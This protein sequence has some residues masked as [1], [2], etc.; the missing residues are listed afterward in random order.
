MTSLFSPFDR[1]N[2]S[3]KF[4]VIFSLIGGS[5]VLVALVVA[6][7]VIHIFDINAVN[8]T[9]LLKAQTIDN[10]R[11]EASLVWQYL[12][13][14]AL[15]KDQ[16]SITDKADPAKRRAD[17][18]LTEMMAI[19]GL[20]AAEQK[21]FTEA[22]SRLN[23][24]Y[25]AGLAMARAYASDKRSGDLAMATF[26][27]E[28][29]SLL[30]S[31]EQTV[32]FFNSGVTAAVA[33]RDQML[34]QV[35]ALTI[36]T[37]I[38]LIVMT[39]WFSSWLTRYITAPMKK[40]SAVATR[41]AEG[42]FTFRIT[43]IRQKD[44]LGTVSHEV[45]D[46]ADQLE[47][48]MKEIITSIEFAG[49]GKYYRKP[50]SSGLRGMLGKAAQ[51]VEHSLHEQELRLKRS[52]EDKAYLAAKTH[53]LLTAMDRFA[54]GDLTMSVHAEKDDE[55]GQLFAGFNRSVQ[56]LHAR[57][58]EVNNAAEEATEAGS[59][60]SSG[61]T[62]MAAGAEEQSA[63][64]GEVASAMEEMSRS[65]GENAQQA[66]HAVQIAVRAR[67]S[68]QNGGAVV[69]KTVDG[70]EKITHVFR[71]SADTM[72]TLG[73]SSSQIGEIVGVINDIA[74]Q[75]NLLALNAA[76]EAA[77]AGTHGRGFAVVAD[78]VRK[79]AERTTKATKEISV[80]IHRIQEETNQAVEGIEKGEKDVEEERQLVAHAGESLKEIVAT[81]NTVTDMI[82][83]IAAANSEQAKASE[84][85][86]RNIV[87]IAAVTNENTKAID[88]I[89]RSADQV[90]Q[91][92]ANLQGLVSS[93]TLTSEDAGGK[94]SDV[95][96]QPNGSLTMKKPPLRVMHRYD[97]NGRP[98]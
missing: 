15:T 75:T 66:N 33:A 43:D 57:L 10:V 35:V 67:Q 1:L 96:V 59:T 24:M 95:V 72:H 68:A 62:Q 9:A 27:R 31:M 8:D 28:A 93:F 26:D 14:A 46:M 41:L 22:Q 4:F 50:M 55:I 79:L 19:P 49:Q 38:L 29:D 52:E 40:I 81:V 70:M 71:K 69:Q 48:L 84:D 3:R 2:L 89:S 63:Q 32:I 36:G 13:D 44:E 91:I 61:T 18:Y 64:S 86:S 60:I 30:S 73:K 11:F 87:G 5:S 45:N 76:I 56:N 83:T 58:L 23:D 51:Q 98:V 54:S 34:Y 39:L 16:R 17:A 77:R 82:S 80:M 88:Q 25:T 7:G 94:H 74:D 90:A 21:H 47:A 42:D 92:T 78:E 37:S 65:I 53:E 12:T 85:I 20:T 97:E 6:Y